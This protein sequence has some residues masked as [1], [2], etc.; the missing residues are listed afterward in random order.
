MHGAGNDYVLLDAREEE[1]DWSSL[2]KM[3]CDRHYGVGSDGL[4]VISQSLI[5]D[6]RMRMFNPDGSKAEM[7]GNGIRCFTKYVVERDIS[8]IINE[9]VSIET[10]AGILEVKP[11]INNGE[12]DRVRVN[13]GTPKFYACDIPVLLPHHEQGFQGGNLLNIPDILRN[14]LDLTQLVVEYPL[15]VD[16]WDLKITC[17]SMGNPHAVAFIDDSIESIPLEIL[18]PSMERH[19]LFPK[20]VN[21]H[22]V[23]VGRASTLRARTWERGAGLTLACGTGAG[24]IHAVAYLLGLVGDTSQIDMPGGV[25]SIT[26]PGF[27]SLMMEGPADQ[28]FEGEWKI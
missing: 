1:K 17:V 22:V 6:I 23:N 8:K 26:W 28:V 3:M 19:E 9:Q 27:G 18:G 24:A 11:I 5:A 13:M 15:K 4:L 2:A 10:D 25:L 12:V 7:C 21:F 16:R 14:E 20:Q